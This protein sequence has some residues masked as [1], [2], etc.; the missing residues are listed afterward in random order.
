MK[1]I[2]RAERFEILIDGMPLALDGRL[3]KMKVLASGD[4]SLGLVY[5][6]NSVEQARAAVAIPYGSSKQLLTNHEGRHRRR[7][8]VAAFFTLL[9]KAIVRGGWHLMVITKT[10]IK[11]GAGTWQPALSSTENK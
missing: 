9:K 8:V 2:K 6:F 3:Q 5:R 4:L 10:M 1:Q 11:Q 7:G